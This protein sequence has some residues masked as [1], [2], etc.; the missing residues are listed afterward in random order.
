MCYEIF[1]RSFADS[2]RDGIGDLRGLTARLD[3]INDGDPNSSADLGA[4]CIWLM[5]ISKSMSYHGYDVV[6]YYHVDPRY[7]TDEDF[8]QLM[9]EAHRRGIHVIVDFVPN[10]SGSRNPYFQSALQ[11]P[12]S[13]YRDGDRWSAKPAEPGPWGQQAWHKS[14]V[15]DE[16]YYGVFWHEMPDLNYRTPAVLNEMKKVTRHWLTDMGADGFRFDAIP[17]LVE[18]GGQLKHTRGT[19]D[20]L[21]QLG[22]AIRSTAPSSFTVGEMADGSAQILASYYPDQLDAYFAF[23]VAT[24]TLEAAR[25]GAAAPFL[26]AVREANAL[27]PQG[28]WAPFLSNHDQPR[29]MTVLGDE[30]KARI[31]ASA[32]LMLPG[33]PFVYYGEEIG[34]VGPKPD[35][36]IRTPMQWSSAPNGG[37]TTGAPWEP[38][39]ADWK[40]KNVT[41][42]DSSRQSLL[43]HYRKLI[44]LRNA[45]QAL[46]SGSITSLPTDDTTGTIAAWLRSSRD[47]TFLI[48]VNFGPRHGRVATEPVPPRSLPD[49]GMSRI[50]SV[51][52]D[53]DHACAGYGH[54]NNGFEGP[55]SVLLIDSIEAHGFCA[56]RISRR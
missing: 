9:R 10:H 37:F 19:H 21:R 27:F 18:E 39:Q 50:Q 23:D 6:D 49:A 36:T 7:G 26:K 14:P 34:M 3:Y 1:V 56:L 17:Y 55:G 40:T 38:L 28:R 30:A 46:S 29:V 48:V 47:T 32:M 35:E 31:A 4:R 45:H 12:A 2:D 25:T 16:Y 5:P 33:M 54:F 53:P 11:G 22:A 51:Y 20:V 8:R 24:G 52:A 13:P 15:R 42:Q 43:N 41:V 44:R